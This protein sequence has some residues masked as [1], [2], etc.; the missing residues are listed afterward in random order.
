MP[1]RHRDVAESFGVD[2]ERYDRT[3]PPYPDALIAR[4][5]APEVLDVGCGT[6]IEARQLRAA[7]SRVLGVEPDE[8]MAAFARAGGI[9]VE[10]ATFEAWDPAGR[11]FDAVVAGQAWHWVAPVAGAAK[12]GDVLRAGGRFA[13]FWHVPQLPEEVAAVYAWPGTAFDP[14]NAVAGYQPMFDLT[15]DG[16]RRAGAFEEPEEW[17]FEWE[18][19]YRRDEWLDLMPTQ[20]GLTRLPA[21]ALARVLDAVGAAIDAQGG[22]ITVP[23]TTVAVTSVR[24]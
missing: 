20:G 21:D 12:A 24:R 3:R 9:E 8:R 2:P 19:A 5:A 17:R 14:R 11:V 16:L 15:A 23:Y 1:W 4:V 18:R 10:V 13:A 7:G 6:G 22:T